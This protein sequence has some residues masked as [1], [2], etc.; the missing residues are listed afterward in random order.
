MCECAVAGIPF[1]EW[2]HQS[3][4]NLFNL[5][6]DNERKKQKTKVEVEERK[7]TEEEER[8]TRG[9]CDDGGV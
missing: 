2:S 4:T 3:L 5:T 6:C 1:F 8:V 7:L 9:K